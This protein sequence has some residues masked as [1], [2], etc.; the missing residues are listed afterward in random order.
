MYVERIPVEVPT[1]APTGRTAC[2][3]LGREEALLVDPPA[4]DERI[5]DV[6]GGPPRRR[7]G[8][9]LD[10]N[11]LDVHTGERD[12]DSLSDGR[13]PG[14][15][16]SQEGL[17]YFGG[18]DGVSE[19]PLPLADCASLRAAEGRA[20]VGSLSPEIADFRE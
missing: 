10:R 8:R 5:E 13:L 15:L 18:D 9:N 1:R 11:P 20:C 16:F 19:R 7:P 14:V 17:V 4:P 2:H 6:A 3:V 12:G